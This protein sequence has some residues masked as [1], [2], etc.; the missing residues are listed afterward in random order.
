[1]PDK[2]QGVEIKAMRKI[3]GL[4][5]ADMAKRLDERTAPETVSRWEADAQPMG[6]H[7]DKVLRLRDLRKPVQGSARRRLQRRAV[8]NLQVRDPWKADPEYQ[9]PPIVLRLI[10][11][12][13]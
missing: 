11:L 4:T 2:L 9:S 10:K 7:A 3:M 5:L 6:G 12:K 13:E 1:M 8:G